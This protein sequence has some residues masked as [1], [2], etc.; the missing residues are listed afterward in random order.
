MTNLLN[1]TAHFL[2]SLVFKFLAQKLYKTFIL[3]GVF[4]SPFTYFSDGTI[5]FG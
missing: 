3:I 1:A 2:K 4:T 5:A